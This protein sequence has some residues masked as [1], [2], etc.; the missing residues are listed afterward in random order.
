MYLLAGLLICGLC[1][2]RME[3]AWSSSKPTNR[4]RHGYTSPAAPNSGRPSNG[5]VCEDRVLPRLSALHLI[6]TGTGPAT[7][8]RRRTRRGGDFRP[9]PTSGNL[10]RYLRELEI[11]LTWHQATAALQAT[12]AAGS[13][14]TI[15]V[16]AS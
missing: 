1:G 5:Y 3:S 8:Q 11:T 10:I 9:H 2:R 12:S 14:K 6:L 15:T 13:A 4:C 7:R 16:T